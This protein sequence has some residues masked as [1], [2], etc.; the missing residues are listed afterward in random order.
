MSSENA[1]G[2]ESTPNRVQNLMR[3]MR[4]I[5]SRIKSSVSS[6]KVCRHKEL[7]SP[8]SY[9]DER[10]WQLVDSYLNGDVY[11]TATDAAFGKTRERVKE[12]KC[13]G[14]GEETT[15]KTGEVLEYVWKEDMRKEALAHMRDIA[16]TGSWCNGRMWWEDNVWEGDAKDVATRHD[17]MLHIGYNDWKDGGFNS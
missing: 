9:E 1:G 13:L 14:C 2:G 16:T 8:V 10:I 17:W 15:I 4:E 6:E 7:E 11:W 5:P 3:S 12:Y